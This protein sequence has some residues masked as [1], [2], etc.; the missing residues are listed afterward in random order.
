MKLLEE[1]IKLT[2]YFVTLNIIFMLVK[3]APEYK[4][5]IAIFAIFMFLM[6]LAFTIDSIVNFYKYIVKKIEK[7]TNN[8]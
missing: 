6:G 8:D 4:E 3:F 2:I 5:Y 1:A 7:R